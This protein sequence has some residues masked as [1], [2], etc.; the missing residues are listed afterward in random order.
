VRKEKKAIVEI[1]SKRFNIVFAY[2][3]GSKAKGY[4]NERGD[5]DIAVYLR[6]LI[7]QNNNWPEFELEAE[8]SRA[9][10]ATVQ[11]IV[12]NVPLPPV[13]GFEIMKDGVVLLDRASNLGMDFEN[14]TLRHYY[15]WQYFLKRQMDSGRHRSRI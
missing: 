5:W 11:I 7:K 9:V 12:L 8:L 3:F 6:E 1:L 4:T 14:R 15:D 10:G 2:F 13:F